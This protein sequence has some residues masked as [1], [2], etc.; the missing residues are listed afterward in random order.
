MSA[1]FDLILQLLHQQKNF[2]YFLGNDPAEAP[3]ALQLGG[4][5]IEDLGGMSDYIMSFR[6]LT[7]YRFA[8]GLICLSVC[9]GG[10]AGK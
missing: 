5:N 7:H 10:E 9:S 8:Y 2:D 1:A 4:N 6:K 3:L